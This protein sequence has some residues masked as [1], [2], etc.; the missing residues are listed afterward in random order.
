M[1]RVGTLQRAVRTPHPSPRGLPRAPGMCHEACADQARQVAR[2]R[3]VCSHL[4]GL[5]FG[6]VAA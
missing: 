2:L 1:I 5:K 6:I 4:H 3:G